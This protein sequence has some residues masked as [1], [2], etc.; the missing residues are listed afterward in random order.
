MEKIEIQ[1]DIRLGRLS[2]WRVGGHAEFFCEPKNTDEVIAAEAWAKTQEQPITILGGGSN[3]LISDQ[4]VKG[5]VI[6]T[7]KLTGVESKFDGKKLELICLGGTPKLLAA[8]KFQN[9]GMTP[10]LFLAGIPGDVAGGVVM[11]AGVGELIV[12]REFC[13]IV[14]W[15]EVVRD[16][17]IIKFQNSD[18]KWGYRFSKGWEPGIIVRVAL[19]WSGA[20]VDNL[21]EAVKK[22]NEIRFS[23]QPLDLPSCGSV[24]VNPEGQ[25]A[26]QL[27]EQSGLKGCRIGDAQVST[28][29]AN[30]IVNLGKA[31]AKEIDDLIKHV[32]NKVEAQTGIR[33]HNEVRYLGQW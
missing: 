3:C 12:P 28:K 6:S 15:F 20:K 4:G 10:A 23:K 31:T 32:Q 5:L 25:K 2:S 27:I 21:S 33:L 24:F 11:N 9:E 17:K 14:D 16:G 8:K 1:K 19:S 13:E 18:I 22:A 29:H 26:A 7:R 30:F